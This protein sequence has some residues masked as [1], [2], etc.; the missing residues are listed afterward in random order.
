MSEKASREDLYGSLGENWRDKK[1]ALSSLHAIHPVTL[2]YFMGVVGKDIKG[3]RI[4]DAGCGGGLLSEAFAREG[5][6]VTGLDVKP[7][8]IETAR[9][10]ATRVGLNID[11]QVGSLE[12]LKFAEGCFDVVI[13]SFVLEHV[14]DLQNAAHNVARVL[15]PRGIF[16]YSGINRTFLT[17][18]IVSIGFQYVLR[19]IPRGT[20]RWNKFVRPEELT[21]ALKRYGVSAVETHGVARRYSYTVMLLNRLRGRPAGDFVLTSNMAMCYVGH[22]VKGDGPTAD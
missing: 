1:A 20:L 3:L 8:A 14:A 2:G 9:Q 16:L 6:M 18:L 17:L 5:A 12:D 4:L 15:K 19:K 22:A 13:A 21:A 10:H 11:Y 7:G